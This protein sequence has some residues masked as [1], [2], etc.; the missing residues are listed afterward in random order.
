MNSADSTTG[1]SSPQTLNVLFHGLW[2]YEVQ[3]SSQG[4]GIVV[5][6]TPQDDHRVAAGGW[7]PEAD[8][9]EQA[10]YRLEGIRPGKR[11]EFES[12]V[13][14]IFAN[15]RL[16]AGS[17]RVRN[18]IHLPLPRRISSLRPI[19]FHPDKPP[20]TG[21]DAHLV[22]TRQISIVQVFTYDADLA[23]VQLVETGK[24]AGAPHIVPLAAAA[25]QGSVANFYLFA[26]PAGRAHPGH[27]EEAFA[28]LAGLYGLDLVPANS[29]APGPRTPE[30]LQG[31]GWRDL[32]GLNERASF[33]GELLPAAGSSGSNC[34]PFVVDNRRLTAAAAG[35]R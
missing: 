35:P 28:K 31:V 2:A 23:K 12:Q 16:T 15:R 6:T 13:N 24:P 22:A 29:I 7:D 1:T 26:Q 9:R 10:S 20:Y 19:S 8:L 27:F 11:D 14:V 25:R 33:R 34:D 5:R 17:D 18:T 32:V 3:D 21:K 4:P 30:Q